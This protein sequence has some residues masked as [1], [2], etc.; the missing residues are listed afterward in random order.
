MC[1][2]GHR[3]RPC[4]QATS[5]NCTATTSTDEKYIKCR[6]CKLV[7]DRA[8]AH[9][10][11]VP[12]DEREA[13]A[14]KWVCKPGTHDPGMDVA[15]GAPKKCEDCSARSVFEAIRRDRR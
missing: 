14:S 10:E 11:S 1:K 9:G 5:H 8:A 6:P 2:W 13:A 12:A 7:I 4:T 3:V 15:D